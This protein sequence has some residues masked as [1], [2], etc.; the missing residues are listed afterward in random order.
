MYAEEAQWR[1]PRRRPDEGGRRTRPDEGD[2]EGGPTKMVI[3]EEEENLLDIEKEARRRELR[4]WADKGGRQ[5]G[6]TKM[7]IV[8]EENLLDIE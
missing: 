8:E 7:V 4:R 3:V 5:R 2:R 6:P 1:W